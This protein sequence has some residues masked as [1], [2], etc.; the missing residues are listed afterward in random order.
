LSDRSF[1]RWRRFRPLVAPL[2]ARLSLV[3]AQSED[4]AARFSALGSPRVA[5]S[6]NLKWDAPP[7]PA[8]P[9]EL[10]R[11]KNAIVGHPAWL[12][13]STHAGEEDVV[14]V[15][16]QKLR[17]TVPRLLT[18]VVPRHPERGEELAAALAAR[19]LRVARRSR[20]EPPG[21]SE[22][23][24]ADTLGELGLFYR[25]A[26]IA[27]IGNSLVKGGG[28]NPAEA[29]ELGAAVLSGPHVHNFAEVFERLAAAVP[30]I[31]ISD[32][33]TLAG[34]VGPLLADP[35]LAARQAAAEAAALAPLKGALDATTAALR[36]FLAAKA[37]A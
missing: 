18:I 6:G 15:A 5:V 10:R 1:R 21:G 19:G 3:M 16:H 29:V 7:L 11:L 37:A 23:Y 17:Q 20:G 12:A 36:P 31:M 24:L 35:A 22:L 34:A 27:F 33:E 30:A 4:D 26:P 14:A 25:L 28:H 8:D 9:A 32:A 13:A 2:F